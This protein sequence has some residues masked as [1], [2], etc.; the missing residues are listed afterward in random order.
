MNLCATV[1]STLLFNGKKRNAGDVIS[2]QEITEALGSGRFTMTARDAMVSQ[3]LI[4]LSEEGPDGKPLETGGAA[5]ASLIERMDAFEANQQ[6]IMK[7]LGIE[8]V[9]AAK[10]KAKK[11]PTAKPEKAP[12]PEKATRKSV[13]KA[14]A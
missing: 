6:A 3:K 13:R 4:V 9:V 7:H 8:P 12:K 10:K 1:Q 5:S 11:T 2:S 14:A